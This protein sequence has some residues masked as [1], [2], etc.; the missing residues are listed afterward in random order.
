MLLTALQ[1]YRPHCVVE[2]GTWYGKSSR[3]ILSHLAQLSYG[4]HCERT[5][6]CV[7]KFKNNAIYSNLHD[8]IEPEDKMFF[9]FLRYE[10]FVSSV[11]D[12][13]LQNTNIE[14]FCSVC[15][16]KMDIHESISVLHQLGIPV[17][18]VFIDA[19]KKSKPLVQLVLKIRKLFPKAVIVGDDLVFESVQIAITRL[20][21]QGIQ[22][23]KRKESY[24]IAPFNS[25]VS[26]PNADSENW[27]VKRSSKVVRQQDD[28]FTIKVAE[29]AAEAEVAVDCRI[30]EVGAAVADYVRLGQYQQLNE[31][32]FHPDCPLFKVYN[33]GQPSLAHTF[34]TIYMKIKRSIENSTSSHSKDEKATLTSHREEVV[35]FSKAAWNAEVQAEMLQIALR[36]VESINENNLS[37]SEGMISIF[38]LISHP[39]SFQ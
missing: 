6:F 35:S 20:E 23:Y 22:A 19:E 16:M 36:I 14:Q 32:L 31:L 21:A 26:R 18:M 38:D 3:F 10:S 13:S 39:I 4:D 24:L 7:D 28:W 30:Y 2:L 12:L 37:F 29:Q 33:S 1:H 5:L 15:A 9:N 8:E 11:E 25:G 27:R 34:M 17:D